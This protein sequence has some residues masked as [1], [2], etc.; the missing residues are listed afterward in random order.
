MTDNR[1]DLGKILRQRRVMIP[2]TLQELAQASGV[3]PSHLG[4]IERGGRFPSARILGRIAK[5]L[6]FDQA[7]LLNLA[8]YLVAET[9]SEVETPRGQLDP[10]VATLLSQESVEVQRAVVT[11]LSVLKS[12]AKGSGCDIGFAEYVRTKYP[13]VDKDTITLIED[14]LD[15]P[16]KASKHSLQKE[17]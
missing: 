1:N 17:A 7:E 5:P 10:Y 8:G 3:S 13:G 6:G 16:P 12:M 2:L 9:P 11:I 4:R 14:I 15:H